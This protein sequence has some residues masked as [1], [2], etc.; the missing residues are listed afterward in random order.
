M[1]KVEYI[2]P[3]FIYFGQT[4]E[5]V[6]LAQSYMRPLAWGVFP[7]FL[8][9]V[10]LQ[11]IIGLGHTRVSMAF[12]LGWVPI[13]ILFNYTL[14][15]GAFGFPQMGIA[16]IGWGL[17]AS[18]WL[19]VTALVIYL[20]L[21]ST[22]KKYMYPAL[23]MEPAYY[24]KEL[25]QVGG[26]LGAMYCLEVGFFFV[27]TLI[28]GLI[29]EA[30]LAATQITMQYLG[31]LISVVF[32]IAQAVTVRMGHKL[33]EKDM[34]AANA[35]NQAGIF[36]AMAFMFIVAIIYVFL[37][38]MLIGIDL[39]LSDPANTDVIKYSKQF[40]ALCALFQ[41]CEAAR[42]AFLGSLRALKDTRFTLI[43]SLVGFW[44]I[45]LPLS[46]LFLQIGLG[47]AGLW[48][49]MAAGAACSTLL[50]NYRYKTKMRQII[51][52]QDLYRN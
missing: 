31:V 8:T 51:L 35:T 7:D 4:Q 3:I 17:T 24:L 9:L 22:Y 13:A 28:M 38:D 37:P 34:M 10:L 33:G 21:S 52:M 25:I 44:L 43:A 27:L 39:K 15:F 19:T 14:I 50:L 1:A 6:N 46:N 11:F 18:Y 20:F 47:G 45:P 29:G 32:S 26:P 48:L 5:I 49:G 36:L 16:G 30:Q 42:I 12:M 23:S 2:S 40:L 41:L